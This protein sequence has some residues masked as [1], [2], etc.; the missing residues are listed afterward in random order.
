[1]PQRWD[2]GAP[3]TLINLLRTSPKP[4]AFCHICPHFATYPQTCKD[5]GGGRLGRVLLAML[6]WQRA[7]QDRPRLTRTPIPRPQREGSVPGSQVTSHIP[8][9]VLQPLCS[10]APCPLASVR[11]RLAGRA[12]GKWAGPFYPLLPH[13]DWGCS[14]DSIPGLPPVQ[15]TPTPLQCPP[16]RP[17]AGNGFPRSPAPGALSP[18][19]G[20]PSP[21]L[22]A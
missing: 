3:K 8:A 1:M 12:G 6:E 15:Q 14:A 11:A 5:A 7:S 16:S 9:H 18:L 4:H 17:S 20:L 21:H 10:Q 19:V 22:H 13:G 2:T